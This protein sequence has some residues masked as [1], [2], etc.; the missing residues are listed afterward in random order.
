MYNQG[1]LKPVI[2]QTV[3]M[4]LSNDETLIVY[5]NMTMVKFIS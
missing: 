4:F 3:S 5:F 1:F 2:N